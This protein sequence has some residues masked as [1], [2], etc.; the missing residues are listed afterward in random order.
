MCQVQPLRAVRPLSGHVY[1]HLA[2]TSVLSGWLCIVWASF[3]DDHG[4]Y[5]PPI[6]LLMPITLGPVP[7]CQDHAGPKCA[8]LPQLRQCLV[9]EQQPTFALSRCIVL[10]CEYQPELEAYVAR[11]QHLSA[12]ITLKRG[13]WVR[14]LARSWVQNTTDTLHVL[15][16]LQNRNLILETTHV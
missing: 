10:N 11:R 3:C 6:P 7:G 2:R 12:P 5:T 14:I 1:N 15:G 13:A 8:I 16:D 4:D 9:A